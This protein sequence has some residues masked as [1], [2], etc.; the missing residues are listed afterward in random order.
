MKPGPYREGRIH[1]LAD[2][3]STCV[4]RPGNPMN[5]GE[6][7]LADLIESNLSADSALTCHQTLPNNPAYEAPPA[8]CRGFFD[9]YAREVTALRMAVAMDL[10]AHDPVSTN[11]KEG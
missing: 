8:L 9:A 5:L 6:G 3:C 2:R 1:V 7:R 4:F 10:I 11:R